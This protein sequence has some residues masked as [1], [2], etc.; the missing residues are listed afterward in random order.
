MDATTSTTYRAN[1][2]GREAWLKD[3]YGEQQ[4]WHRTHRTP[5]PIEMVRRCLARIEAEG[6]RLGRTEA[7]KGAV[8]F[9]A[10]ELAQDSSDAHA[11]WVCTQGSVWL[12]YAA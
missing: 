10:T 6:A 5:A 11:R 3:I 2:E 9:H 1:A 7:W 4:H 8:A 12:G